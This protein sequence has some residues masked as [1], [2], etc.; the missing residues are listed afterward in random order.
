MKHGL[1][2][3]ALL[4]A[5]GCGGGSMK[6]H[7]PTDQKVNDNI[8]AM[9]QRDIRKVARSG[10]WLLTRSYSV[11]GDV[12]TTVARGEEVSH[13]SIYDARTGTIIE[14]RRPTVQEV[15]LENLLARNDL[16]I[17][18]RPRSPNGAQG[19]AS[20][21]RARAAVGTEFDLQGML[22]LGDNDQKFYCSE[23]VYWA[24]AMD[25][26]NRPRI[27]TPASLVDYGE[28]VY[29]GGRRTDPQVQ[30]AARWAATDR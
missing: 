15:P 22:G 23:L 13:A 17:V 2:I 10:D 19:T 29:Y 11:N 12:I 5:T 20:V 24:S 14:A 28:V 8:T 30:E 9:W 16:V 4:V 18:V 26:V 3:A 6:I 27:I 1:I 21:D 7:K 25:P